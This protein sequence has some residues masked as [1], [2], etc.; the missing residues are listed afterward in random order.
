MKTHFSKASC[1]VATGAGRV[2]L[3]AWPAAFVIQIERGFGVLLGVL[4]LLSFDT[5]A[6]ETIT[7][8]AL[9]GGGLVLF[10]NEDRLDVSGCPNPVNTI[11]IQ[12]HEGNR[13]HDDTSRPTLNDGT[14]MNADDQIDAPAVVA[15]TMG[16]R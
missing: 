6:E 16:E 8:S 10:E 9:W 7:D 2:R 3:K 5:F 12:H 1:W 15:D 4:L 11:V 13:E 14:T